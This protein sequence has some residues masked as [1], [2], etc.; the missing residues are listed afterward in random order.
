M[1]FAK[2]FLEVF[3]KPFYWFLTFFGAFIFYLLNVVISDFSNLRNLFGEYGFLFS[4]RL[5]FNYFIGFSSTM[6]PLSYYTIIVLALL[7][8]TYIALAIYKTGQIKK[9]EK[10][11]FF[12]VLGVFAGI[13]AP[14]CAACGLGLA[15]LFGLGGF[16][17][18]LPFEGIEISVIS[19][20][21]LAYANWSIARKINS[22]L[23]NI[24][25]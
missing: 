10:F 19:F 9:F 24:N 13:L 21:L 25:A 2:G 8:G 11:S 5:A 18:A 7:F 12:G 16:L 23:C 1:K 15:S 4:I 17:I 22:N 20:L 6:T 3:S 14:G